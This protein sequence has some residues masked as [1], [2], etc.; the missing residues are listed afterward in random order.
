MKLPAEDRELLIGLLRDLTPGALSTLVAALREPNSRIGT[1]IGSKNYV[2][3]Q[4]LCELGLAKEVPLEVDMP[5]E[6]QAV[7]R[8]VL[9]DVAAKH[10]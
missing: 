8:S 10:L 3:L 1:S 9:I 6:L 7:L 5:P 2:F 4:K